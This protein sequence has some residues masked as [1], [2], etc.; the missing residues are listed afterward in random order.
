M[1]KQVT[2]R[3]RLL[4]FLH[5]RPLDRVPFVQYSGCAAPDEDIWALVGRQEMGILRWAGVHRL[6]HPNCRFDSQPIERDGHTGIRTTLH[7]PAG[8]LVEEKLHGVFGM[9]TPMH[10]VK[11]PADYRVL[12]AYL[13]DVRVLPDVE[14][15]RQADR[16]V[17]DDGLVHTSLCRTPYPQLW[18]QWVCLEDLPLHMAD[19]PALMEEVYAAMLD[20]QRAIFRTAV[21]ACR[22]VPAPYLILPDNITAGPIGLTYFQRYAVPGYVELADMLDAAGLDVLVG[23]HMDGSLKPLWNA[24]SG[25]KVRLLDSL[26]PPPD[27]DTSVADAARLWPA[28]RICPNFPSSIHLA[29]DPVVYEAAMTML[30]QGGHTGRLQIQISENVPPDSWRRTYPAIIR[31]IHD[32]GRP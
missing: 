7:T 16:L 19:E 13:R 21:E 11:A 27:G 10:F 8:T 25:S 14:G 32:F 9:A 20:V 6:E 12:L 17:G 5:G 1:S 26:N 22:T 30:K 23:V 28:M 3:Q 18:I 29:A 31:A 24:I 4:N 2:M 15:W